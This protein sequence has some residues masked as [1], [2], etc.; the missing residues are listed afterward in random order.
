MA[1]FPPYAKYDWR[2]L[3][4]APD[5][6]VERTEMERGRPKHRRIASDVRIEIQ[7][8]VRFDTKAQAAAFE[9]WF[10]DTIKAGQEYFDWQHPR[11]GA[12]LQAR[13]VG[14]ELGALKF[15]QQ[16]LEASNR[17]LKLEYW[18]SAW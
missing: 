7:L 11:T 3:V 2:D 18:R 9:D 13:V 12:I 6:V 5:S 17:S 16:T 15:E 8:T 1:S 4:E 14:G 10:F